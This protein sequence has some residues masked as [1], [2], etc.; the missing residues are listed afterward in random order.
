[1]LQNHPFVLS[2]PGPKV[3]YDCSGWKSNKVIYIKVIGKK[4]LTA[5]QHYSVLQSQFVLYRTKI[6]NLLSKI[7]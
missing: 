7:C 3:N 5:Q 6:P 1:M 4:N 2:E